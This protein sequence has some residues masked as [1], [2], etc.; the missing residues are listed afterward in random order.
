[1][2]VLVTGACGLLGAHLL[3]RLSQEH[4]VAGLDR[5]SWWSEGPCRMF[6]GDMGDPAVVDGAIRD[7]EPEVVVH[8]AA[9]VDVDGC[10][11]DPQSAHDINVGL[12]RQL[13]VSAPPDCLFVYISTDA[14]FGGA[15]P[16]V[17][18]GDTPTPLNVYG[19]TKLQGESEVV[20][21]RN[22]Y[23]IVRTNF[24]GWSS[25]RKRTAGEWLHRALEEQQAITLFDDFFLTPT[26]VVDLAHNLARLIAT[27]KH[28]VFHIAGADRVSKYSFGE[29][30]AEVGGFSMGNVKR[31]SIDDARMIAARPKDLSLS[32]KAFEQACGVPVA[33]CA[34]GIER[35]IR[36]RDRSLFSRFDT[37]KSVSRNE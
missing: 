13:A 22:R 19:R 12:T 5:N 1:V 18:E 6:C 8:C 17:T 29:L 11:R 30:M 21:R 35:F 15:R 2:N 23:L 20:E 27:G 10:E 34:E 7:S 36:D 4:T 24:Y 9:S 28:G 37:L 31:G 3:A 33:G 26:Y 25:G 32:S 14:V 16:F